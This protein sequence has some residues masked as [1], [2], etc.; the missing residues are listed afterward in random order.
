MQAPAGGAVDE[1][2]VRNA[3]LI[4]EAET[5]RGA[6]D[7]AVL[8]SAALTGPLRTRPVGSRPVRLAHQVRF[9]LAPRR[10]QAGIERTLLRTRRAVLGERA[11]APPRFLVRVDEF[12]HARAWGH[13]ER[14]GTQA[15][16]RFHSVLAEAGLAYLLAV[17][18]MVCEEP[19]DPRG[20]ESRR[21]LAEE[22]EMLRRVRSEGALLALHGLDHRTR[23]DSPRRHSELSGL[24]REQTGALLDR[25]LAELSRLQIERPRVFVAPYNRFDASQVPVLAERFEVICGGP[26]SIGQMGIQTTPQWRGAAVYLPAYPPFY[27]RAEQILPA[28]AEAIERQTGLWTPIVL[29]WEWEARESFRALAELARMIAPYSASWQ[30]LLVAIAGHGTP[31]SAGG[32]AGVSSAEARSG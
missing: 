9:K 21:M 27:G 10:V 6:L 3:S 32:G 4:F 18:P 23:F 7:P 19:L 5:A 24:G 2:A 31:A 8:R 28:A 14:F 22:A 29:H 12:P 13:G 20:T 25:G 16:A 26:E 15:Y 1:S 30:D 11:A 17:L